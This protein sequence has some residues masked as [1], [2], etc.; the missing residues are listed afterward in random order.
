[1]LNNKILIVALLLITTPIYASEIKVSDAWARATAPGQGNGSVA[2]LITSARDA[3][4][5]AVS[6][7][8]SASAEIHTMT[9][10]QGVM[11]MRQLDY[12]PLPAKQTVTLGPGGDHLM[13]FELK[14]PLKEGDFV[15][16]TLTVQFADKST[17][18]INIKAQ[19]RPLTSGRGKPHHHE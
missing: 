5:V 14:K 2:L 7:S 18:K 8:V 6:S 3:R 9:M 12:L 15:P 19:I 17:E 13:L 10:D 16:L 11:K 1:M 4:L